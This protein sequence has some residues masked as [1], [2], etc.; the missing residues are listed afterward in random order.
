MCGNRG[1]T[2]SGEERNSCSCTN[3]PL[4]VESDRLGTLVQRTGVSNYQTE[5]VTD[6]EN[7][8]LDARIYSEAGFGLDSA[9]TP[10]G[11]E[12]GGDK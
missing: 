2:L 11:D 7:S 12:E 5:K 3:I 10:G 6:W 8:P 9:T 4:T 1:T